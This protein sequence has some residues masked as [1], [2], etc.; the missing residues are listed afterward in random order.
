MTLYEIQ[1]GQ[2]STHAPVRAR[3]TFSSLL[4]DCT[5]FNSRARKGATK[6]N[7]TSRISFGVSTHA[8]VRARLNQLTANLFGDKSFNSRARKGATSFGKASTTPPRRFNSRA[9]KGAT[10][11]DVWNVQADGM[12]QLTRP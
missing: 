6:E 12:F 5:R 7:A 3:L 8:P 4:D 10:T 9:R 1:Q 11:G 2:V